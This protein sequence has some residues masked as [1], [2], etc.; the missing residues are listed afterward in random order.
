MAE[1]MS[2]GVSQF[3]GAAGGAA[4]AA[5]GAATAAG[6][7]VGT[8]LALAKDEMNERARIA[9]INKIETRL[10][11]ETEKI[12]LGATDDPYMPEFVRRRVR[13]ALDVVA[14]DFRLERSEFL[15]K[16][17]GT[18]TNIPAVH[19]IE[20][21]HKPNCIV[22][23]VRYHKYPF[24]KSIWQQLRDPFWLLMNILKAIPFSGIQPACFAVLLLF[25]DRT[26]EFQLVQFVLSFKS[27]QF[28][29]SGV[30]LSLVG[31]ASYFNCVTLQPASHTCAENG[32]GASSNVY[33]DGAGFV[34]MIVLTW[35]SMVLMRS[36]VPKGGT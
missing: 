15:D 32:P 12:K 13:S 36:A 23:L 27:I 21:I 29:T 18:A 5:G 6:A 28:F 24:D 10:D 25:I 7:A 35:V 9:L 17:L 19:T 14:K 11:D 3:V 20:G 16:A 33:F 30:I 31:G 26:D 1:R 2:A 8:N 34:L 4:T 22:A